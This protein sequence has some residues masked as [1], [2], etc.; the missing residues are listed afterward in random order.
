MELFD[1]AAGGL[2]PQPMP[3]R[4]H[5]PDADRVGLSIRLPDGEATHLRRVLRLKPGDAVRV[6]DGRGHE[7]A[8]RVESVT[9]D[10]VR[11]DTLAVADAAGEPRVAITLAQAVLKGRKFDLVIRDATMLGVTLV[12][13]LT[14]AHTDTPDA[15]FRSPY[16]R[17]RW[18]RVAVSSAKQSGR[19]IV[20]MIH[21]P[22][23]FR[24]HIS[25]TKGT[26]HIVLVEP[27]GGQPS[28]SLDTL[29][30]RDLPERVTVTIGPEGGW[31]PEE[32]TCARDAGCLL[33]T[34]GARTLRAEAVPVAALS[35]QLFLWGEL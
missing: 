30:R 6:F 23:S 2:T 34:L 26:L 11:V 25:M 9:P 17:A 7:L 5:V 8:A 13:P 32:V 3:H 12:Q 27:R 21:A 31:S 16:V 10:E 15:A 33:L 1:P 18:E 29:D 35:L 4:F 28:H 24:Q 19:A 14:T 20:P 22:A